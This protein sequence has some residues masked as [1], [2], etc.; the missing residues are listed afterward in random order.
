[1][2]KRGWIVARNDWDMVKTLSTFSDSEE[3]AIDK[4][5]QQAET[6]DLNPFVWWA[7]EQKDHNGCRAVKIHISLQIEHAK[8]ER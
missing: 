7:R 1:M 4:A 8:V 6:L 3:E 2:E 5:Y